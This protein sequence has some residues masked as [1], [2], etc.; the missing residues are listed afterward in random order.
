VKSFI[1]REGKTLTSA[2]IEE[3]EKIKAQFN[4]KRVLF[5]FTHL[6]SLI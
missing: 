5:D 2:E 1:K 6:D 3:I 4:K